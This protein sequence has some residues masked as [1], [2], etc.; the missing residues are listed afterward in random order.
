[1]TSWLEA[2]GKNSKALVDQ[3]GIEISRQSDKDPQDV[4]SNQPKKG[5]WRNK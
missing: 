2:W 5:N 1:M 4:K 3:Y